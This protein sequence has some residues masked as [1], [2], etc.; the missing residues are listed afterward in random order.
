MIQSLQGC[1][2]HA[3][4]DFSSL[5]LH[6]QALTLQKKGVKEG[7]VI[8]NRGSSLCKHCSSFCEIDTRSMSSRSLSNLGLL[9]AWS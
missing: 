8:N 3:H 2:K 6:I 9:G 4:E 5:P 7:L 1:G